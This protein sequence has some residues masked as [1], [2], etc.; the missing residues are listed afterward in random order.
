[1]SKDVVLHQIQNL[2][3][4]THGDGL[5]KLSDAL[6]EYSNQ[7]LVDGIFKHSKS[8]FKT[9]PMYAIIDL[10]FDIK[11]KFGIKG[12]AALM[13]RQPHRR[14]HNPGGLPTYGSDEQHIQLEVELLLRRYGMSSVNNVTTLM[15]CE[16]VG[17]LKMEYGGFPVKFANEDQAENIRTVSRYKKRRWAKIF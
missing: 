14:P 1:M 4:A 15:V 16:E 2:T 17:K 10:G 5:L 11:S 13:I 7:R 6:I 12:R 8:Q 3:L 9:L